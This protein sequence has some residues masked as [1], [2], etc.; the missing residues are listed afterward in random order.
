MSQGKVS[1]A[2]VR[3]GFWESLTRATRWTRPSGLLQPT[4][5]GF[6]VRR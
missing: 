1:F 3:L 2:G 5:G 6:D 4:C